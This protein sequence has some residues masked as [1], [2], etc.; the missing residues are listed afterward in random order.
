MALSKLRTTLSNVQSE[1]K[2]EK[3]SSLAKDNRFKSL[4]GLVIKIGYDLIDIKAVEDIIKKTNADI[5]TLRKQLKLP[6]IEDF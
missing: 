1:L 4:E 2:I 6:S 3:I 5:T